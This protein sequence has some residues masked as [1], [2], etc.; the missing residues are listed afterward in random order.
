MSDAPP[1]FE[2]PGLAAREVLPL[3]AFLLGGGAGG[4]MISKEIVKVESDNSFR[5]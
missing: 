2:V 5:E 1:A 3:P 4:P